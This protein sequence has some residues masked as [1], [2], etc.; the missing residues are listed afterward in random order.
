M[1]L[2]GHWVSYCMHND[3]L[4]GYVTKNAPLFFGLPREIF[5]IFLPQLPLSILTTKMHLEWSQIFVPLHLEDSWIA[6]VNE[7]WNGTFFLSLVILV[8]LKILRADKSPRSYLETKWHIHQQI[9]VEVTKMQLKRSQ[10]SF[11]S[12]WRIH[13][14]EMWW[15]F[16]ICCDNGFYCLLKPFSVNKSPNICTIRINNDLVIHRQVETNDI[17]SRRFGDLMT[18][19]LRVQMR[20]KLTNASSRVITNLH[21]GGGY[22]NTLARIESVCTFKLGVNCLM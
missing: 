3:Q 14:S 21:R 11:L 15:P 17:I 9:H 19:L 7:P 22:T 2:W 5:F 8:S 10:S 6:S 18:P 20:I 16:F 1:F 12:I 13:Q 4:R